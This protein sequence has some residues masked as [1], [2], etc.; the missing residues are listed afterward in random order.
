MNQNIIKRE[1]KRLTRPPEP[2]KIIKVTEIFKDMR[3]VKH[4]E[5]RYLTE[6]EWA[7]E[8]KQR[9][10]EEEK[11]SYISLEQWAE[12]EKQRHLEEQ[13]FEE[14]HRFEEQRRFEEQHR[15]EEQRRFEEQRRLEEQRR[16]E[17]QHRL[18]EQRHFEE[19]RRLK[20]Q[21]RE[22]EELQYQQAMQQRAVAEQQQIQEEQWQNSL[23]GR[24]IRSY[25]S[26]ISNLWR[27]ILN[28]RTFFLSVSNKAVQEPQT[29]NP[30]MEWCAIISIFFGFVLVLFTSLGFFSLSS[31]PITIGLFVIFAIIGIVSGIISVIQTRGSI[32]VAAVVGIILNCL[33]IVLS[34]VIACIMMFRS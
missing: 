6:M 18:E 34:F 3:G 10:L 8:E 9:R 27:I 4:T 21:Q 23:I 1:I 24:T 15:L 28:L 30:V 7:E 22:V 20:E 25:N 32:F 31:R 11:R 14:Q 5:T 13:H 29:Y 12:G 2:N 16:F 33:S 17:E 19:Q 26:F